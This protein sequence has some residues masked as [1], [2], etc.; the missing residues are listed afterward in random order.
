MHSRPHR[1]AEPA[2]LCVLVVD[3]ILALDLVS[4]E[5][6]QPAHR[7]AEDHAAAVPDVHRSRRVDAAELHLEA[8][9]PAEIGGALFTTERRYLGDQALQP[10][11]CTPE[12]D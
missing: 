11:S 6:D 2:G 3:V 10:L 12:S 8:L 1:R 5:L 7:I 4:G 9:A